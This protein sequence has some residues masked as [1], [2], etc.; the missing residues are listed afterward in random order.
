MSIADIDLEIWK[1]GSQ[2]VWNNP[3]LLYK[4]SSLYFTWIKYKF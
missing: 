4:I 3:W 1:T 2:K